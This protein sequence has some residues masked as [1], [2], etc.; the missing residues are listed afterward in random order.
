MCQFNPDYYQ[1][2]ET[3]NL[4]T[5]WVYTTVP[6][7]YKFNNVRYEIIEALFLTDEVEDKNNL[8]VD[9]TLLE[10]V[11]LQL[12]GY[13]EEANFSVVHTPNKYR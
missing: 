2:P 7:D 13:E 3:E 6:I 11:A 1:D 9:L 8:G 12:A 10:S 5:T 4:G